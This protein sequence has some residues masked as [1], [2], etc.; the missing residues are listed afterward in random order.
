[1]TNAERD[2]NHVTTML[3]VSSVDSVT[4]TPL[5]VNPVTWRIL[6]EVAWASDVNAKVSSADTT[7]GFLEDK[8]VAWTN[9]TIT[10]LNT[11]AN[12]SLSIAA[13]WAVWDMTKAVYDAANIAEQLVWLVAT[14]ILTNKTLT[15]PVI[16]TPTWIVKWDVWLWNVDNTSDATKNAAAVTLTN[17]TINLTSN[18]LTWTTAQFN[19]A[20][21]DGSFTTWWGTATWTNTWDQTTVSWNAWTATALQTAR[22][23]GW[24]SFDWTA[25]IAIWALN[26]TNVWA[27]TSA[28]LAWVIS[29]ETWSWLLVFWTS[30]TLITPLLW[31]PTSWVLTN[32]TWT[33][34][35]LTSWI[36]NAL[37]SATTTVNVS[38]ATAPS[39]WQ[40]LTATSSTA[41]TWQ[42]GWAWWNKTVFL[43]A[44]AW[45]NDGTV[46]FVWMSPCVN[47][48]D[49]VTDNVRVWWTVPDGWATISSVK[50][51]AST[52]ANSWNAY[53]FF[54]SQATA[55]WTSMNTWSTTDSIAVTTYAVDA[56]TQWLETIDITAAMNWLTLTAWYSIG[57]HAQRQWWDANDTVWTS[58]LVHWVEI[59]YS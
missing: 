24:T 41:A 9:I 4:P 35:W 3:W 55:P 16:N 31:T 30:P 49:W 20:L 28:E 34:T 14:Q 22:T 51:H 53:L 23:I 11:W 45:Q 6:A 37:K 59:V 39:V 57:I 29:N 10:K 5:Q 40:V 17:K 50:L 52:N 58:Y 18:T 33:A 25:N 54:E 1:M 32:C 47:M 27:T 48:A 46:T 7:T 36:T 2:A 42:A 12:E 44:T 56:A 13:T 26:S 15:S 21:S 38:S 43:M 8:I 19:T